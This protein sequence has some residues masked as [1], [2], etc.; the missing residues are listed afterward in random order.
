MY[1]N[2]DIF[3]NIFSFLNIDEFDFIHMPEDSD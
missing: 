1:L 3:I 2:D